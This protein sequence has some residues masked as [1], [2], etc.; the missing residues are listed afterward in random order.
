M[1]PDGRLYVFPKEQPGL[2]LARWVLAHGEVLAI[3][4]AL[5]VLFSVVG[6]LAGAIEQMPM[7]SCIM[8]QTRD[9]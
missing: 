5:A 2:R 1:T 4:T 6:L 9:T 7:E 8:P 3:S